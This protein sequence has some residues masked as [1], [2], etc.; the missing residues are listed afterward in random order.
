[1]SLLGGPLDRWFRILI[2]ALQSSLRTHRELALENLALQQQVAVWKLRQPRP[3]LA[4]TYRIF[5]KPRRCH[6][7]TGSG[8]TACA[9]TSQF[10]HSFDRTTDA[11]GRGRVD[12]DVVGHD[13]YG[14]ARSNSADESRQSSLGRTKNPRRTAE[15]WPSRRAGDGVEVHAPGSAA[16]VAG[17]ANVSKESRPGSDC[18]GLLHGAHGDLSSPFRVRGAEPRPPPAGAF[19]RHR[20]SDGGMDGAATARGVRARGTMSS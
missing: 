19:Q 5:S 18:V 14:A 1:I 3:Y 11:I 20:A 15:T 10:V 2:G 17:V 16:T 7:T 13:Q 6:R 12:G 9:Q 4:P 8:R